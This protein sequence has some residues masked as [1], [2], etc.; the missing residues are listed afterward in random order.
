MATGNKQ[1]N[2][3]SMHNCLPLLHHLT[4]LVCVPQKQVLVKSFTFWKIFFIYYIRRMGER[5]V[6]K[7]FT[8]KTALLPYRDYSAPSLN[9]FFLL[10]LLVFWQFSQ[11]VLS[12]LMR[13]LGGPHIIWILAGGGIELTTLK[14][15]TVVVTM[16]SPWTEHNWISKDGLGGASAVFFKL[17]LFCQH[18]S[19]SSLICYDIASSCSVTITFYFYFL[20]FLLTCCVSVSVRY[21]RGWP[22]WNS[23]APK[24]FSLASRWMTSLLCS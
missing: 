5:W 10:I 17:T 1:H 12:S 19:P 9:F 20:P 4:H 24:P 6:T 11:N 7:V 2:N 21:S 18:S 14:Y 22:T 15:F 3:S 23:A 8:G 16:G 13:C